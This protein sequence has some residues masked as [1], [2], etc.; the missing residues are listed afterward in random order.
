MRFNGSRKTL[1]FLEVKGQG[2]RAAIHRWVGTFF[3]EVGTQGLE[4]QK[5]TREGP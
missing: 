4:G 3:I 5:V 2:S 1:V